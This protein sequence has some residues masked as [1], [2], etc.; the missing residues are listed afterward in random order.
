MSFMPY[1]RV[2]AWEIEF[3]DEFLKWWDG[4]SEQEQITINSK[5]TLLQDFG[6]SLSRPHADVI[7]GSH[8]PNMKELRA[9]H[10]GRPYRI[11]FIFDPRR[12][13]V[14]LI[15]G[16]KTGN[17]A[18]TRNSCRERSGFTKSI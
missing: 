8:Y 12:V 11:L 9:Q 7:D 4:L 15:G 3:T 10:N 5:V 14:L 1:W 18:G 16:D 6:P 13:G 17:E 2:M